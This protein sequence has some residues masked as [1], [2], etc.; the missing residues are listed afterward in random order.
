MTHARWMVV[1]HM[2]CLRVGHIGDRL[3]AL[4]FGVCD[5]MDSWCSLGVQ[6]EGFCFFPDSLRSGE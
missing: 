3:C 4:R 6:C 5:V 2:G 1:S